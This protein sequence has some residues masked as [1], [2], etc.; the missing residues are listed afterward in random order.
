MIHIYWGMGKGKTSAVNGT[1]VRAIGADL[2]V[3]IVRFLKGRETSEDKILSN[4]GIDIIKKHSSSKFIIEMNESEKEIAKNDV[5]NTISEV[6]KK[7]KKY[8]MIIL[9]EALD[10]CAHNVNLLT[11]KELLTFVKKLSPK[12]ILITGHIT[13]PELFDN[14]DLISEINP[15][16]HYFEKGVQARKGIDF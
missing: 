11:Q 6:I 14:A 13:I 15:T 1:A 2:K 10:L 7:F 4:I 12:E 9:D 3:L 16:R 5:N 8:D